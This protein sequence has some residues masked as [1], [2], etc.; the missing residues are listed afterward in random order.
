MGI[1]ITNS[2]LEHERLSVELP[3]SHTLNLKDVGLNSCSN[4]RRKQGVVA[5]GPNMERGVN[6]SGSNM[7]RGTISPPPHNFELDIV[8]NIIS[9]EIMI[10]AYY[11]LNEFNLRNYDAS[12]VKKYI[13]LL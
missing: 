4:P 6:A 9:F 11:F 13:K 8:K 10:F 3:F 1:I 2:D 7:E 12:Q 5:S